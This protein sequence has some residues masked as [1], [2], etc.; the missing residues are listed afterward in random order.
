MNIII[1]DSPERSDDDLNYEVNGEMIH[2]YVN[3]VHVGTYNLNDDLEERYIKKQ[4]GKIFV[5][6][7]Y[8]E[9]E[10]HLFEHDNDNA[11]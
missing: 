5:T 4:N 7:F 6:R 9:H 11:Q 8:K 2:I 3:N 1:K 10:K